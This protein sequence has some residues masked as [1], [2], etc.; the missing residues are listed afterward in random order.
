MTQITVPAGTIESKAGNAATCKLR[1]YST[2]TFAASTGETITGSRVT[3]E[4]FYKEIPCTVTDEIVSYPAFTL[5]S[6]RDA[7]NNKEDAAYSFALYSDDGELLARLYTTLKVSKTPANQSLA[8]IALANETSEPELP[9]EYWTADQVSQAIDEYIN[10]YFGSGA[11]TRVD[12]GRITGGIRSQWVEDRYMVG[13]IKTSFALTP[14]RSSAD[15]PAPSF[16]YQTAQQ[17][18]GTL[19]AEIPNLTPNTSHFIRMHTCHPTQ[20]TYVQIAANNRV[21]SNLF[22]PVE[23]LGKAVIREFY[24]DSDSDGKITINMTTDAPPPGWVGPA[25][26]MTLSG[27]EHATLEP[28]ADS[29][30]TNI[31]YESHSIG[32]GYPHQLSSPAYELALLLGNANYYIYDTPIIF[33][34]ANTINI[35]NIASCGD[36]ITDAYNTISSQITPR[37]TKTTNILILDIGTNDLINGASLATMQGA[38]PFFFNSSDLSAI[39]EKIVC[40]ILPSTAF[41]SQTIADNTNNWLETDYASFADA[42]VDYRTESDLN[43][44]ANTSDG[45]HWTKPMNALMAEVL[46][47]VVEP[48]IP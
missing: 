29:V 8:S 24:I 28:P 18:A 4:D 1:V 27:L 31:I 35:I 5:Q 25:P 42:F 2:V 48:L 14:D 40:S 13:G 38:Y 30:V 33:D 11:V 45:T 34:P 7:L 17:A 32:A 19:I 46:F 3:S 23:D 37:A 44:T 16:V 9:E 20:D 43:D 12:C 36:T 6:T 26:L 22:Y 47:D 21:A 15:N 39:D 10:A 41:P